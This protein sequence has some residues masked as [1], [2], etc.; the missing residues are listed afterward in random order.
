LGFGHLEIGT[1]TLRPQSGNPRPRLFRLPGQHALINRM[2]FPGQGAEYVARRLRLS[3]P[4]GLVLGV[5]LGKNKD[6]PL[7]S[8]VED[9]LALMEAFAPLADYLAINV[10]SP[11]TPGL[12]RLQTAQALEK[13]LAPL[14][15][16]RLEYQA[17][18]HRPLPLL[19]KLSPDLTESELDDALQAI[20]DT[21]VDGVI[22][23][24]TTLSR[25]GLF[26]PLAAESGG[27]SGAPLGD[28]SLTMIRR[29]YARTGGELPIIGVGGVMS[30]ANARA[31]LDVGAALVQVYTGLIYAGPGLV[32]SILR[33]LA[34][35]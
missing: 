28:L 11:N 1:V 30:A 15:S 26:S 17:S 5:N 3:R 7:E 20:L 35:R 25:P 13:L 14:I 16:R 8:A 24:N 9:Y 34:V 6:T 10:S 31:M 12:R 22:A 23:A 2:G 29:I 32:Q 19:V 33:D 4:P 27:L 18:I 21:G